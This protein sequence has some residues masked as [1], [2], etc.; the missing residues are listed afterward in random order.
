M[1][2]AVGAFF[3]GARPVPACAC[4]VAAVFGYAPA[5]NAPSA[6]AVRSHTN[7]IKQQTISYPPPPPVA[8]TRCFSG[9]SGRV[10]PFSRD[11]VNTLRELSIR[12]A[13]PP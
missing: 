4:T 7:S 2:Y 10:R 9:I 13:R 8:K 11:I 5:V 1:R 6:V 3:A 12:P